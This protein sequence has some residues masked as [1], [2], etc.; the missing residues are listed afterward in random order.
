[1][2]FSELEAKVL[3]LLRED[4]EFRYAVAGML[5]LEEIL[6]R[7]DRHGE[8][9]GELLRRMDRHES[10]LEE[11]ARELVKLREDFNRMLSV[12][13]QVREGQGE[14]REGLVGLEGGVGS[15]EKGVA[16]LGECVGSLER[17]FGS[18]E[19]AMVAGFGEVSKFAGLTFGEFVR[20]FLTA[21]FREAGEI[22]EG[23]E[24]ANARIDGEE[25]GV[26]LEEPLIVGEVT[27]YAESAEEMVKLLRKAEVAKARYSREPRKILVA[28]TARREAAGE[29]RRRA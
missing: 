6:R 20:K 2:E 21:W 17:R 28:L 16:S 19:G 25:V 12:I 13:A 1:M 9:L 24:L 5:G 18:L 29:L 22:P 10:V 7:L 26:F 14:L 8:L 23:A 15:L 4:E 3:A 27:A 11:H